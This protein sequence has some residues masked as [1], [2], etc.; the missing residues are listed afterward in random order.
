MKNKINNKY[1][2]EILLDNAPSC[3]DL[4]EDFSNCRCDGDMDWWEKKTPL[5]VIDA[6]KEIHDRYEEGSG[7][8][9]SDD[10]NA[11]EQQKPM[12]KVLAYVKRQYNKHYK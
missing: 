8:S 2:Y 9:W 4:E 6:V 7:W 5:E 3:Y 12:K 1:P 10:N 11:K